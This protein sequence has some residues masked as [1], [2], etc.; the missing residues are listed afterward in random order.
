[1]NVKGSKKRNKNQENQKT[2]ED[3]WAWSAARLLLVSHT[4]GPPE[5]P[6]FGP[7]VPPGGE[8]LVAL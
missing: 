2:N 5:L 8:D 1:M 4:A 6:A 7:D 3:L